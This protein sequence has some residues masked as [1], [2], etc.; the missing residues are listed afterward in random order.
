MT[1]YINMSHLQKISMQIIL[2]HLQIKKQL[3]W[4]ICQR[5]CGWSHGFLRVG[6]GMVASWAK[7]V[8][9]WSMVSVGEVKSDLRL[10]EPSLG[11][12]R[13]FV[14]SWSCFLRY[15]SLSIFCFSQRSVSPWVGSCCWFHVGVARDLQLV[16]CLCRVVQASMEDEN[17]I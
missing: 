10:F 4:G 1:C 14:R 5:S 2:S 15:R 6:E 11:L 17:D 9:L 3:K 7:C 12:G 16:C 8:H 13:V